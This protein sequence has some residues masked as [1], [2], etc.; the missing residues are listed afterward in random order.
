MRASASYRMPP[1]PRISRSRRSTSGAI[2]GARQL[3]HRH[4]ALDLV[5]ALGVLGVAGEHRDLD[6]RQVLAQLRDDRL[7]DRLVAEVHPAVRA[8]NSY[9]EDILPRGHGG[10]LMQKR[11]RRHPAARTFSLAQVADWRQRRPPPDHRGSRC[12]GLS[13]H[14]MATIPTEPIGSIPRPPALI[15]AVAKHGPFDPK[16]EPLYE[17]AVRDTVREFEAT[18]SPVIADGEQRKYH[19]FWDYSG[20][21][22]GQHRARRLSH[23]VRRRAHPAHAA[24]DAAGRS[25]TSA[26]PTRSSPRRCATPACR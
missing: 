24:P 11:F 9:S 23:P 25:A 17:S 7:Q 10:N 18:G 6:L 2:F 13:S 15:E 19:N 21:G 22:P 8:G 5:A 1:P 20:A 16:L 3:A 26:T 12:V 4:R 14:A